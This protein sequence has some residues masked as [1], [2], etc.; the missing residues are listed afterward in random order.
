MNRLLQAIKKKLQAE[1][2][3]VQNVLRKFLH[4]IK[5][6]FASNCIAEMEISS[7]S[8]E[9]FQFVVRRVLGLMDGMINPAY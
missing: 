8:S 3:E 9:Q 5:E 6:K 1:S 2:P 7:R 4:G